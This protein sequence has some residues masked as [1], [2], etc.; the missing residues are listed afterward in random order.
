MTGLSETGGSCFQNSEYSL[1]SPNQWQTNVVNCQQQEKY[2]YFQ[3]LNSQQQLLPNQH[4]NNCEKVKNMIGKCV[5]N[6]YRVFQNEEQ[7]VFSNFQKYAQTHFPLHHTPIHNQQ[8]QKSLN[9]TGQV[10]SSPQMPTRHSKLPLET[11]YQ[12][13]LQPIAESLVRLPDQITASQKVFSRQSRRDHLNALQQSSLQNT[14]HFNHRYSAN[15]NQI[16]NHHL[17][18]P[19]PNLYHSDSSRTHDA[20]LNVYQQSHSN[21][22]TS[23]VNIF[24]ENQFIQLPVSAANTSESALSTTNHYSVNSRRLTRADLSNCRHTRSDLLPSKV[25]TL[26]YSRTC[27]GSVAPSLECENT[28][29]MG[30]FPAVVSSMRK[31][32]PMAYPQMYEINGMSNLSQRSV[33]QHNHQPYEYT[34]HQISNGSQTNHNTPSKKQRINSSEP[35]SSDPFISMKK[36]NESRS[37]NLESFSDNFSMQK[38]YK[39]PCEEE[40][41]GKTRLHPNKDNCN[42]SDSSQNGVSAMSTDQTGSA[43]KE[44]NSSPSGCPNSSCIDSPV[45]DN[46]L[47]VLQAATSERLHNS[48]ESSDCG[49]LSSHC[50][51]ISNCKKAKMFV[52]HELHVHSGSESKGEQSSSKQCGVFTSLVKSKGNDT[53][54]SNNLLDEN[55]LFINFDSRPEEASPNSTERCKTDVKSPCL[56]VQEEGPQQDMSTLT[57]LN[58]DSDSPSPVKSGNLSFEMPERISSYDDL[59]L[60]VIKYVPRKTPKNFLDENKKRIGFDLNVK[61]SAAF[62]MSHELVRHFSSNTGTIDVVSQSSFIDASKCKQTKRKTHANCVAMQDTQKMESTTK[63]NKLPKKDFKNKRSVRKSDSLMKV[64]L[65]FHSGKH[66]KR[67]MSHNSVQNNCQSSDNVEKKHHS[68]L[69]TDTSQS[70]SSRVKRC[71][72]DLNTNVNVSQS[73]NRTKKRHLSSPDLSMSQ[74]SKSKKKRY[75]MNSTHDFKTKNHSKDTLDLDLNTKKQSV[76]SSKNYHSKSKQFDKKQHMAQHENDLHSGKQRNSCRQTK[77][78]INSTKHVDAETNGSREKLDSSEQYLEANKLSI[79][80]NVLESVTEIISSKGVHI[81]GNEALS[82]TSKYANVD[83]VSKEK[84]SSVTSDCVEENHCCSLKFDQLMMFPGYNELKMVKYHGKPLLCLNLPNGKYFVMKEFIAKCFTT[85]KKKIYQAKTKVLHIKYCE[86]RHQCRKEVIRYLAEGI[87]KHNICAGPTRT[88]MTTKARDLENMFLGIILVQDANKLYHHLNPAKTNMHQSEIPKAKCSGVVGCG[89]KEEKTEEMKTNISSEVKASDY[90]TND[91]ILIASDQ[92]RSKCLQSS[93]KCVQHTVSFSMNN[94]DADD[95]NSSVSSDSTFIYCDG[96]AAHVRNSNVF[97]NETD[98]HGNPLS[99]AVVNLDEC[100]NT[101]K[102]DKFTEKCLL[103][104]KTTEETACH[105]S[106]KHL[107]S[108]MTATDEMNIPENCISSNVITHGNIHGMCVSSKEK[109]NVSQQTF[110]L[111]SLTVEENDKSADKWTLN[112][113]TDENNADKCISSQLTVN[114]NNDK[115]ADASLLIAKENAGRCAS[116]HLSFTDSAADGITSQTIDGGVELIEG[117]L[118]RYLLQDR[119]KWYLI[120]DLYPMFGEQEVLSVVQSESIILKGCT[121]EQ[122]QYFKGL[123]YLLDDAGWYLLTEESVHIIL[124]STKKTSAGSCVDFIN[125]SFGDNDKRDKMSSWNEEIVIHSDSEN[126]F[127][128]HHA[129]SVSWMD[130]CSSKTCDTSLGNSD[131][132]KSAFGSLATCDEATCLSGT[133][134]SSS[135]TDV[136]S[137]STHAALSSTC[138]VSSEK[139]NDLQVAVTSC[140]GL[141]E[142]GD[143]LSLAGDGLLRMCELRETLQDSHTTCYDSSELCGNVSGTDID[144]SMIPSG[145][146]ERLDGILPESSIPVAGSFTPCSVNLGE[147]VEMK[148]KAFIAEQS[149]E[150]ADKLKFVYETFRGAPKEAIL[151]S[152]LELC[153]KIHHLQNENRNLNSE[154]NRI[155][156][157]NVDLLQ[158]V[159]HYQNMVKEFTMSFKDAEED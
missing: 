111:N 118:L 17:I 57:D 45:V 114:E 117:I 107:S 69:G 68:D 41:N 87:Q 123:N 7:N 109:A 146:D 145:T 112:N 66:K 8:S 79:F 49:I 33:P 50:Q 43:L 46:E 42:T 35:K 105:S 138:V 56:A 108:Q 60:P 148:K 85:S 29:Q 12:D 149:N 70:S 153:E 54:N 92:E 104:Q 22:F 131:S 100:G 156:K 115:P 51:D 18:G 27:E 106:D 116:S 14:I 157:E 151:N 133:A 55:H 10:T 65:S 77:P 152:V 59:P 101:N 150:V 34:S 93:E 63:S 132:S 23:S 13:S 102:S 96:M 2:N 19:S 127:S 72:N 103:D 89:K 130:D 58:A 71:E 11:S 24:Q 98:T 124:S 140:D 83:Q 134:E 53:T 1:Y 48:E 3:P 159:Q 6:E 139:D 30:S 128:S 16:S 9:S 143:S 136:V 38:W 141:S 15:Q 122:C 121:K 44:K 84:S 52:S 25:N 82:K 78:S 5:D 120:T 62:K 37:S 155:N 90:C 86:L 73:T 28:C 76:F 80:S 147:H 97:L 75:H 47:S 81:A 74:S 154:V 64:K 113:M 110:K 95:E 36:T 142:T 129:N 4:V 91:D 20:C 21:S 88:E 39:M 135:R 137:S 40:N 144:A 31:E 126:E 119:T 94:H 67:H 61:N 158:T 99:T 125:N 32:M 26:V